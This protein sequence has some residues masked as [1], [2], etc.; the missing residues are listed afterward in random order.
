M[1]PLGSQHSYSRSPKDRRR[2]NYCLSPSVPQPSRAHAAQ[3]P[4]FA[5]LPRCDSA[6]DAPLHFGSTWSRADFW[7]KCV[8]A[9]SVFPLCKCDGAGSRWLAAGL[10][11]LPGG[12]SLTP[13][14]KV[15]AIPVRGCCPSRVCHWSTA[16]PGPSLWVHI[17]PRG[18]G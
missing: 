15:R 17:S 2:G 14:A 11:C 10:C 6:W 16:K 18:E 12:C 13:Q 9:P 7:V 8:L 1:C 3:W 5:L 4:L